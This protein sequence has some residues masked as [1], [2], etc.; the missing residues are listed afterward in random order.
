MLIICCFK[1]DGVDTPWILQKEFYLH[2]NSWSFSIY[3]DRRYNLILGL[4]KEQE[5]IM[6]LILDEKNIEREC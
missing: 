5:Q 1:F 6:E 4:K 3:F 2:R